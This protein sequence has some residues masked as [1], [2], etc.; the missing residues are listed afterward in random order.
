MTMS[1]FFIK[2]KKSM[3]DKKVNELKHNILYHVSIQS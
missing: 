1:T 3:Q 2:Y